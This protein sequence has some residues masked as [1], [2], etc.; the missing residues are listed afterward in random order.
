MSEAFYT[1]TQVRR[2]IAFADGYGTTV[3]ERCIGESLPTLGPD[4]LAETTEAALR[5]VRA[6]GPFFGG[7]P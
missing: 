2:A 3:K 4:H 7:Y 5:H 1:E 6:I